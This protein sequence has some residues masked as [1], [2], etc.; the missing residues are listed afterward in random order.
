M[1]QARLLLIR[2][3]KQIEKGN[4]LYRNIVVEEGERIRRYIEPKS[5]AAQLVS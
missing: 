4:M 3:Q 1:M 5:M 2:Q